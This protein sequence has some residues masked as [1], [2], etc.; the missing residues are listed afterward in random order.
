MNSYC[1]GYTHAKCATC[2]HEKNWQIL[3]QMPNALRLLMQNNME[4]IDSDECRLT[5]MGRHNQAAITK[6]KGGAA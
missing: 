4:K 3:N 1:I 5:N 2:E 6:L